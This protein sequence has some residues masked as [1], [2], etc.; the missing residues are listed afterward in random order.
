MI[1]LF[2][3]NL[4]GG[5]RLV[6]WI[7]VGVVVLLIVGGIAWAGATVKGWKVGYDELAVVKPKLEAFEAA[8]KAANEKVIKQ[9]PID[10]AE[11]E[12]LVDVKAALEAQKRETSRA[13]GQVA[14]L[15]E[16]INAETG[17]PVVRLSAGWGVCF[18]AAAA[19][20][21]ADVAACQ[22][23]GGDGTVPAGPGDGGL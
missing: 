3:L 13:W 22:A 14:T 1:P 16:T 18:A 11:V 8:Q 12:K 21:P 7:I 10:E 2:L 4:V 19:G 5:R 20:D 15:K 6:A 9:Q 17:C 23:A